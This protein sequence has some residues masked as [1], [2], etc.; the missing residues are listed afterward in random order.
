MGQSGG[1]HPET[2]PDPDRFLV[3]LHLHPQRHGAG[4]VRL[5][6]GPAGAVSHHRG[7]LYAWPGM[8]ASNLHARQHEATMQASDGAQLAPLLTSCLL[9]TGMA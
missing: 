4:S 7:E 5:I 1:Q 6:W 8:A 3:H 9:E 2:S